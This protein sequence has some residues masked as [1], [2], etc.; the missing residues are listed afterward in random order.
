[1][2]LPAGTAFSTAL[3]NGDTRGGVGGEYE[4]VLSRPHKIT[5]RGM[6]FSLT[7]NNDVT[8]H[9]VDYGEALKFRTYI[10]EYI[11]DMNF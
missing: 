7:T 10:I 2:T 1:M 3:R 5:T 11:D 9:L 6:K 8:T 4:V